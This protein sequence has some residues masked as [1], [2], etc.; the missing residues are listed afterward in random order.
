ME[1][2]PTYIT[3][4]FDNQLV[5]KVLIE[6]INSTRVSLLLPDKPTTC[7][8]TGES[9]TYQTLK[10]SIKKNRSM[11]NI[12]KSSTRRTTRMPKLAN[13]GSLTKVVNQ[14]IIMFTKNTIRKEEL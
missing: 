14:S 8:Y 9:L 6:D 12:G 11:K 4:V 1:D 10:G 13:L 5:K 3:F 7:G 2:V